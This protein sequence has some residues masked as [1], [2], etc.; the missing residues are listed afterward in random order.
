MLGQVATFL[1]RLHLT[2]DEVFEKIPYRNLVIMQR[3]ILHTADS[4]SIVVH[5][6]GREAMRRRM[7][8]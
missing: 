4:D 5:T 3:D 2:Y 7:N 1:E 6:S 8:H